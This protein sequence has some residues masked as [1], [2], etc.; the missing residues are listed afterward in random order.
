LLTVVR[1]HGQRQ[2]NI[3]LTKSKLFITGKI[4]IFHG[5]ITKSINAFSQK[6]EEY[7]VYFYDYDEEE[8]DLTYLVNGTFSKN[9]IY[10]VNTTD[11]FN[12][13]FVTDE[14]VGN[15]NVTSIDDLKVIAPTLIKVSSGSV[16]EY[17]ETVESIKEYIQ[18]K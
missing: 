5:D 18:N 9:T 10:F 11:A 2:S 8:T 6:E 13:N 3:F 16:V 12:S 4:K 15:S 17:Y 1:T 7:Y 14:E